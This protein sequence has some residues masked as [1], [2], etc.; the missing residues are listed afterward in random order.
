MSCFNCDRPFF[1]ATSELPPGNKKYCQCKKRSGGIIQG[2]NM[3]LNG[4]CIH[5]VPGAV[6]CKLCHQELPYDISMAAVHQEPKPETLPDQL[7]QPAEEPK[8]DA[9]QECI[10]AYEDFVRSENDRALPDNHANRIESALAQLAA[11]KGRKG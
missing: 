9:I 11:L 6:G 8:T 2:E 4:Q 3:K 10:E 1:D 7:A 5:G